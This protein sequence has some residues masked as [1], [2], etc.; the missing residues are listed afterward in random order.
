LVCAP[1]VRTPPQFR[2]W[3][4]LRRPHLYMYNHSNELEEVGVISLTGVKVEP[5]VTMVALL[6]V[7]TY[8]LVA[9]FY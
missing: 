5:S 2:T 9:A 4:I 6:G 8:F 1:T 7:S 3:L